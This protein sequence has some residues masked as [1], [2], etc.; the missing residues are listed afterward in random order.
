MYLSI[1]ALEIKDLFIFIHLIADFEEEF[2]YV[3]VQ[4]NGSITYGWT[5]QEVM[6]FI[7]VT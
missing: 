1:G 3:L 2:C 6:F 5:M 7:Y 4:I